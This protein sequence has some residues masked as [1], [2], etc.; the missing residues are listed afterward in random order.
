[1]QGHLNLLPFDME[2][3]YSPRRKHISLEVK[4]GFVVMRAPLGATH[5]ELENF[6]LSKCAWVLAKIAEQNALLEKV[7]S[8]TFATGTL[9]PFLDVTLRLEVVSGRR[10]MVLRREN[11]LFVF[12]SSRSKLPL[13]A[14]VKKQVEAWYRAEALSLLTQKTH[15]LCLQQKLV[16]TSVSVR[17]TRTKW[18]HC[19]VEGEIQY[20]WKIILA[21]VSVVDYL[22][23]HE[24]CHLK[25]HNHSRMYWKLVE[26]MLPGFECERLWLRDEGFRL[27]FNERAE[28]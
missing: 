26:R 15:A 18:G 27:V 5:Q 3:V 1:M 11:D 4:N 9:L 28:K 13:R 19:T 24:V 16:C 12:V 23:T 6:A 20:N 2:Y 17:D 21:P 25:H 22:V 10:A 8:Y 14:Q 7:P